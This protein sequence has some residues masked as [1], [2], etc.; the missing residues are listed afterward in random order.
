MS[1]LINNAVLR[2]QFAD[3]N[4]NLIMVRCRYFRGLL[5]DDTEAKS[6]LRFEVTDS[7]P[8]LTQEEQ[9]TN[10]RPL[11]NTRELPEDKLNLSA[12]RLIAKKID[13]KLFVERAG[14]ESTTFTL[15]L[16]VIWN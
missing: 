1:K 15:A 16:P 10:F 9:N 2:C 6:Y 8:H 14:H 4:I 11:T 12:S 5:R 3:N 7:G 13:A